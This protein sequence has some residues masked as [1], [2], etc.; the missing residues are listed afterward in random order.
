MAQGI[1]STAM[2]ASDLAKVRRKAKDLNIPF[3]TIAASS[4]PEKKLMIAL[5]KDNGKIK[6]VHFGAKNSTTFIEGA[7]QQKRESYRARHSKILLRDGR[8]AIDEKYSN[9]WLSW[10]LLW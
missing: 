1:E 5:I 6:E 10:N 9:A 7:S 3:L 4:K 2:K 8:R